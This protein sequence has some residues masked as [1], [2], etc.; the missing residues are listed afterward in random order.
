MEKMSSKRIKIWHITVSMLLFTVLI[1]IIERKSLND[2]TLSEYKDCLTELDKGCFYDSIAT[3]KCF[4][5]FYVEESKLCS[6]MSGKLSKIAYEYQG[7]VRFYKVNLDK[8]TDL[9]AKYNISGVP[10]IFMFENG[11]EIRRIMG[12]VFEHNLRKIYN[13]NN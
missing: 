2:S 7:D 5:L 10:N 8:Y 12:V 6:M 11:E 3:H 9:N 4:V 13:M 1:I